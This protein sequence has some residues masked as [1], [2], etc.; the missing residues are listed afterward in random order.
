MWLFQ[1]AEQLDGTGFSG[2]HGGSK[3]SSIGGT[4]RLGELVPGGMIRHAMKVS[5]DAPANLFF[6]TSTG[7]FRWPAPVA[8]FCAPTC[9]RGPNPALQLGALLALPPGFEMHSHEKDP[10]GILG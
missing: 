6:D 2:G 4:I 3:L 5:L 9:Y 8:D 7:G 1:K 10:A